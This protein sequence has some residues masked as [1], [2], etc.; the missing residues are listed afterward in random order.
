MFLVQVLHEVVSSSGFG[1][2][3]QGEKVERPQV[4]RGV[5]QDGKPIIGLVMCEG[6][7]DLVLDKAQ[8][9]D[10][11]GLRQGDAGEG[12][13]GGQAQRDVKGLMEVLDGS[14][15]DEGDSDEEMDSEDY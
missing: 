3:A 4:Q 5:T 10:K 7:A 6:D 1:R 8:Q 15:S 11:E 2:N 14:S 12:W 9:M 13:R